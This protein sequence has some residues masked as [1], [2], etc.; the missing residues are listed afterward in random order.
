[1]KS[2]NPLENSNKAILFLT[3]NPSP[4]GRGKL[5][6]FSLRE[7]GWDEGEAVTHAFM[8]HTSTTTQGEIP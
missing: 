2:A 7:K 6:P 4:G 3:L 1:V 5:K 8:N